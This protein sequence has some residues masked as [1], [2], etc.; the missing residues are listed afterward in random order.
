MT[1]SIPTQTDLWSN[2]SFCCVFNMFIF[3]AFLQ[4]SSV[5]VVMFCFVYV[6]KLPSSCY[7]IVMVHSC[8]LHLDP[9]AMA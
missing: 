1:E 7:C 5:A 6:Q 3:V 9:Q 2:D 8:S 4:S